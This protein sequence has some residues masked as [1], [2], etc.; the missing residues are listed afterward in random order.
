MWECE[1][2]KSKEYKKEMKQIEEEIKELEELNPRNA[3]FGGR[4]NATKLRVK[5]KKMKYIDI[6]SLYPTVQCYDDYP[7]GHPTKIFKPRTY[8]SDWYGLIKCAILP[9]KGLYHPVLPVKNKTKSGD[10]KLT[11]PL[12]QLCAKLNN[13]K[14]KC[15][16]TESQRIIR[17]TWCTNEVKEAIEKGYK[18][19]TI[20]EVWHFYKKSSNL[21]K[22][23]VKAFMKIKLE[24]SPWQDDFE[25]EEEYRKAVKENLG[26]ELGKIE[27][28]P[29]KRAVA[30]ICLNSLW[31]KF[32]QR[33]NMGATEYVTDVNS[34]LCTIIS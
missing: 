34:I 20:D 26:I 8:N 7:I 23:Y 25:S 10:E 5:G 30:K 28:N 6:C 14:D 3:F 17:G 11:F 4:T 9:P 33:Q 12:C 32:G 31:G 27:N 24:T 29:G 13:Q 18:I 15:S 21:F 1:W 19:I 2:T 22:G 16:H